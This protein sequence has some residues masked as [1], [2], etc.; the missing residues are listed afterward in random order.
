MDMRVYLKMASDLHLS[1]KH[2]YYIFVN[3][4]ELTM[5]FLRYNFDV[6]KIFFLSFYLIVYEIEWNMWKY[7]FVGNVDSKYTCDV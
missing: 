5:R 1:I 7:F 2:A 6:Y 3:E 4:Y